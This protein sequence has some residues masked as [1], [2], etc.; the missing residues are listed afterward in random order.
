[1]AKPSIGSITTHLSNSGVS[2]EK[3]ITVLDKNSKDTIYNIIFSE[4]KET[5][6][7]LKNEQ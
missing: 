4:T 1:M 2:E 6:S 3:K 7:E 5:K